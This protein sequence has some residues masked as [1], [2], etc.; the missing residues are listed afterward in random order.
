MKLP[1]TT[2]DK[3]DEPL[4][5]F[6]FAFIDEEDNKLK[7]KKYDS[8]I[9]FSNDLSDVQLLNLC[10]YTAFEVMPNKVE[11][12]SGSLDDLT[13]LIYTLPVPACTTHKMTLRSTCPANTCDVVI[14]WGDGTIES[15]ND[16]KHEFTG[17]SYEL[18]HDYASAMS[19]DIQRFIIKI[20]GKDYW[21]FRHNSYIGYNLISRVFDFDLP[22][23][24]HIHNI[25]S[26]CYSALRLL[27]VNFKQ[28]YHRIENLSS[29]FCKCKNL[30]KVTGLRN[31]FK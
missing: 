13:G 27:N 12:I 25:A 4:K 7:I 1:L 6:G 3:I 11:I 23:A 20:Y 28:F 18:I 29:C 31:Y 30:L 8:I 26:T 22:I 16:G 24:S 15:I 10:D 5:G 19:K 17:S 2:K 9:E 21:A 14:D